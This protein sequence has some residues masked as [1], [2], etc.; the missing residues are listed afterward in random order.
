MSEFFLYCTWNINEYFLAGMGRVS[1]R[2]GEG[3]SPLR[4][5]GSYPPTFSPQISEFNAN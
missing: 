1:S 5:F 2:G 4:I 3:P